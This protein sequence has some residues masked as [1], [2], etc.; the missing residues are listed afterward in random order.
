MVTIIVTV[1][2]PAKNRFTI[3]NQNIQRI[4]SSY[5]EHHVS[6][7]FIEDRFRHFQKFDKPP[8]PKEALSQKALSGVGLGIHNSTAGP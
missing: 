4:L 5:N 3:E 2:S 7:V 6:V 1:T 8:L